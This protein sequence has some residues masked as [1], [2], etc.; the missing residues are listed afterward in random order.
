MVAA[1]IHAAHGAGVI[2]AAQDADMLP[3]RF[4][5]LERGVQLAGRVGPPVGLY[6]AVGEIHIR[7]AQGRS[8]RRSRQ[9]AGLCRRFRCGEAHSR[10]AGIRGR[11]GR[12]H[13]P[14]P[15]RKWR[16]L[17]PSRCCAARSAC[18]AWL[19]FMACAFSRTDMLFPALHFVYRG[20]KNSR[21]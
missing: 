17:M 9:P 7:G 6:R 20:I 4:E 12:G 2:Q 10:A 13:M 15:R 21:E 14:A 5:G 8:G 11:A 19:S 18:G 3:H 1:A 16:L